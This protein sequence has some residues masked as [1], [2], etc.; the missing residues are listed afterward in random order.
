M[1][2]IAGFALLIVFLSGCATTP[3]LFWFPEKYELYITSNPSDAVVTWNNRDRVRQ[4]QGHVF[5]GRTPLK[6]K[7]PLQ[8]WIRISKVGYVE[9]LYFVS[10][11]APSSYET[12][13]NL[14]FELKLVPKIVSP[15]E[16]RTSF[17]E[18]HP[19][20]DDRTKQAILEGQIFVGM[21]K[22]QV[23]ASWGKP[24]DINRTVTQY[25]VSEQWIYRL[26]PLGDYYPSANYLYFDDGILTSW[27][28]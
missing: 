19:Q 11:R 22:G 18:E 2:L 1:K 14:H 13:N 12:D 6:T 8:S 26:P 21:T 15:S 4:N 9:E 17:V 10:S 28:D 23:T 5:L 20:L 24:K 3:E 7:L 25:S 27:Q 16:R